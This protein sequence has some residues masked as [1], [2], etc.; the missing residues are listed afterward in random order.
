MQDLAAEYCVSEIDG[1][2]GRRC[3]PVIDI[4]V[5]DDASFAYH[6]ALLDVLDNTKF[7]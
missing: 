4:F 2:L 5:S 3:D 7:F 6:A 1:V